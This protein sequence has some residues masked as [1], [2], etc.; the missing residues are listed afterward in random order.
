LSAQPRAVAAGP[1]DVYVI[2]GG[3]LKALRSGRT[4]ATDVVGLAGGDESAPVFATAE[5]ICVLD[6]PCGDVGFRAVG[7]GSSPTGSVFAADGKG[8]IAEYVP[9]RDR[10]AYGGTAATGLREPHGTLVSSRG[11]LYVPVE[12]GVAVV[13]P[14]S[15][16]VLRVVSLPVTP[17]SIWVGRFS[18]RLFA[19]LYADDRIALVDTTHDAGAQLLSGFSRPVAVWGNQGVAYVYNAGDRSV[20]RLDA[21]TGARLGSCRT[22]GHA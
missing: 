11:R 9:Q 6:G 14:L 21:L 1:R 17:S 2:D 13:D 4:L 3:S 7:L 15:S 16:K 8:T 12:R 10:L 18:G 20:C 19:T 5:R 22:V